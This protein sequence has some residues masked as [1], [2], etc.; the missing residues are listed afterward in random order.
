MDVTLDSVRSAI[1]KNQT[2]IKALQIT[3]GISKEE[4]MPITIIMVQYRVKA[5]ILTLKFYPHMK[6]HHLLIWIFLSYI[7]M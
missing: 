7:L 5:T 6:I 1:E 2:M 4:N 3:L